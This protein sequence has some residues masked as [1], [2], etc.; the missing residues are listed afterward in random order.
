MNTILDWQRADP[1]WNRCML[2]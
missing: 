1:S 2:H